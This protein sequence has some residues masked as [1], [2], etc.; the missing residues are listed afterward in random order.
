MN[1]GGGKKDEKPANVGGSCKCANSVRKK[2]EKKE[3]YQRKNVIKNQVEFCL[4]LV[5]TSSVKA[6]RP[7]TNFNAGFLAYLTVRTN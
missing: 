7:K 5:A 3:K 6:R 1:S 2:G 4:P